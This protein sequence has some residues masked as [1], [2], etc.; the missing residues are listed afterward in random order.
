MFPP[1]FTNREGEPLPLI[2]QK[3]DG[4]YGY[5]AT[6]LAGLRDRF[7]R[8]GADLALYVVGAPQAQ[9][10]EMCFAVAR[11]AG[12]IARRA[13]AVHVAFGNMLGADRKMFRSRAG[14]SVKLADLLDE[15]VDRAAAAVAEKNPDLDEAERAAVARMVGHRGGQVR[16]PVHRPGRDYVFDWD[17]M[18]AFEGNTAPYLQYAHAR[19]RSIFRRVGDR[20]NGTKC[21]ALSLREPAERALAVAAA[22]VSPARWRR[23]LE[24]FSPHKLCAYLFEL[25]GTFTTFYEHCPVLRADDAATQAQPAGSVRSH[26]AGPGGRPRPAGHRRTRP[27]VSGAT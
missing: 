13:E 16:R 6:D 11:M 21:P 12:W 5:A 23:P 1:G 18:L 15:A 22:R 20:P 19:I 10:F 26:R 8:L 9:H 7:G 3:S 25:A 27:H 2:V 14:E 4:G 17:R 24:T